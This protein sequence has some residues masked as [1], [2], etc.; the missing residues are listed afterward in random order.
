MC[1][2]ELMMSQLSSAKIKQG[3][4]RKLNLLEDSDFGIVNK[5]E[6][7]TMGNFI[8]KVNT[9]KKKFNKNKHSYKKEKI[10]YIEPPKG[11]ADIIE[12]QMGKL[13]AT[14][15]IKND[16]SKS[17]P[18]EILCNYVNTQ[19]GLKGYCIRVIIVDGN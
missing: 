9:A 17:S 8:Q 13:M 19:C 5:K 11:Y 18:Q 15:I 12:Y 4:R 14:E 6:I 2:L 10:T 3:S 7:N 16:T 1:E